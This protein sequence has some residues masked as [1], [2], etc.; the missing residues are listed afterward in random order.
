M[1]LAGT[2]FYAGLAVLLCAGG[3]LALLLMVG[4]AWLGSM[5][6]R[7]INVRSPKPPSQKKDPDYGITTEMVERADREEEKWRRKEEEREERKR[8]E[9]DRKR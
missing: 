3:V 4:V 1:D 6:I 7:D 9:R 8:E 5:I 2:F